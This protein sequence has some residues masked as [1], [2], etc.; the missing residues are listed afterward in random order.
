MVH[1]PLGQSSVAQGEQGEREMAE[2]DARKL[3]ERL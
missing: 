3:E 2:D 1:G